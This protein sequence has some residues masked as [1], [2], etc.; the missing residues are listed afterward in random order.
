MSGCA[1]PGWACSK[2]SV[3]IPD[4][5]TLWNT[6]AMTDPAATAQALNQRKRVVRSPERVDAGVACA[7]LSRLVA[8]GEFI[9]RAHGIYSHYGWCCQ[10]LRKGSSRHACLLKFDQL[11]TARFIAIVAESVRI[12]FDDGPRFYVGSPEPE[13]DSASWRVPGR[14]AADQKIWVWSPGSRRVEAQLAPSIHRPARA[15][16]YSS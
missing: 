4:V 1:D 8:A 6:R 14:R 2:T 12:K 11:D 9:L 5:P 7:Q 13:A 10:E 3:D 16:P 15:Q